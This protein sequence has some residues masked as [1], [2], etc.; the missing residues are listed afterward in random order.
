MPARDSVGRGPPFVDVLHALEEISDHRQL[1]G[2]VPLHDCSHVLDHGPVDVERPLCRAGHELHQDTAPVLG[3][4]PAP[5]HARSL[6]AIDQERH[7]ATREAGHVC[8]RTG[9]HRPFACEDVDA[10]HVGPADPEP[11]RDRL[12]VRV[13]GVEE[14]AH[15][16]ADLDGQIGATTAS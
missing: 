1:L 5:D 7:C 9:C 12:V 15:R 16:D 6:E 8:H 11:A 10:P 4:T 13:R 14:L 2:A 3:I